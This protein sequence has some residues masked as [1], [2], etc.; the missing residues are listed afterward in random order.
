MQDQIIIAVVSAIV[1]GIIVWFISKNKYAKQEHNNAAKP[2]RKV[3]TDTQYFLKTFKKPTNIANPISFYL[4]QN[5]EKYEKAII[6]FHPYLSKN[7]QEYLVKAIEKLKYPWETEYI[8]R[9][10]LEVIKDDKYQESSF[11]FY[12]GYTGHSGTDLKITWKEGL[13]MAKANLQ[14]IIDFGKVR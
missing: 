5:M 13:E 11:M 8:E 12:D 4:E 1:S 10:Y 6:D 14:R 2:F 3:F 9:G 7:K